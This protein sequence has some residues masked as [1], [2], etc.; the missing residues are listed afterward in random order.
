ML[1]VDSSA[2]LKRYVAEADSEQASTRSI[3]QP[4]REYVAPAWPA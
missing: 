1:Y 2:F 3:S 4:Q